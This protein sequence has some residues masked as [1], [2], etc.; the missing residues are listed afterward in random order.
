[1]KML[2]QMEKDPVITT[3]EQAVKF[4]REIEVTC[5]TNLAH[6]Y[7]KMEDYHLAIKFAS[8]ALDKDPENKKALF[9]KGFAY[10]QI[11][12]LEK[13]REALNLIVELDG[14]Q[15]LKNAAI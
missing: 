14:D 8:Q 2:F 5:C 9:R 10:K 12:E 6:C 13:A 3:Q 1:M 15:D 7:N 4:I 11:G